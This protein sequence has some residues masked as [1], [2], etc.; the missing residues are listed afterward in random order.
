MEL[1][2]ASYNIHKAV[3]LDRRRDPDRILAILNETGADVIALQEAD[4]RFG[5]RESVLPLAAIESHTPYRAVHL[6][7]RPDSI[8]WHGNALLVRRTIEVTEACAVPLPT[9]EPRGAIRAD[10]VVE[11][12]RLRVVGMHLDLSGLRRR[13]QVRSILSHVTDCENPVPSVLMGDFNEWARHGGC[14]HEIPRDWQ[15]LAPGRSFPSRR[16]VAQL[17]RI[18]VSD[19][20]RAIATGVHHSALAARGSDHL[21][22]WARLVLPKI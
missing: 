10:L 13:Q 12:R 19:E 7:M 18:V 22:V 14:F 2:F 6:G 17:D 9:L 5:R 1:T 15:V 16:P 4:R 8:G 3:G 11:G 21:P 20:W